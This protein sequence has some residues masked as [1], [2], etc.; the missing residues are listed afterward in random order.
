MLGELVL[1]EAGA[2]YV[3]DVFFGMCD[4]NARWDENERKVAAILRQKLKT[5]IE[6]RNDIAH[7]DWW[8]GLAP[9]YADEIDKPILVRIRPVR[10][11]GIEKVEQIGAD[12]LDAYT[13]VIEDLISVV[14]EF[15]NLCLG[16]PVMRSNGPRE[17]DQ[18]NVSVGEYRAG[19][20]LTC[21]DG[22]VVRDGPRAADLAHILL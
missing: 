11:D 1:G 19:D 9:W 5:T 16:L 3:A 4:F 13:T 21:K 15:G 17:P 18:S 6:R 12:D 10:K 14:D 20:I 7:G 2:S 22:E 8:V